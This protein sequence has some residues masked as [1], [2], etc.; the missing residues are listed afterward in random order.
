MQNTRRELGRLWGPPALALIA[1]FNTPLGGPLLSTHSAGFGLSKYAVTSLGLPA[2]AVI[3]G[4]WNAKRWQWLLV[5]G[6]LAKLVAVIESHVYFFSGRPGLTFLISGV[7]DA[8]FVLIVIGVLAAVRDAAMAAAVVGVQLVAA[9][10]LGLDWLSSPYRPMAVDLLLAVIGV[11]GGALAV[12][13]TRTGEIPRAEPIGRRAVIVGT[14]AALVPTVLT[15][16]GYLIKLELPALVAAAGAGVTVLLFVTVL[17]IALGKGALLRTATAG[18]V[19]LAVAAPLTLALYF[20][21]SSPQVYGPA[22][23]IGLAAGMLA[24][25]AGRSMLLAAGACAVLAVVT[26][27]STEL[28][29]SYAD[30]KQGGLASLMIVLGVL[31][32]TSAAA[33]AAP[34]L[35][36]L[37]ALPVAL[38]PLL[39]GFLLGFRELIQPFLSYSRIPSQLPEADYTSLW[40]AILG[41][42]AVAMVAIA[43]LDRAKVTSPAGASVDG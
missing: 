16:T 2:L 33:T 20:S 22:A 13:G 11:V 24:G 4:V 30:L 9:L 31:A 25:H 41:I 17:A 29:G 5:V 43:A 14:L 34:A 7:G 10:F 23:V 28:T 18:L 8:G 40:A 1:L 26:L 36:E 39:I 35:I 12:Y 15:V 21:A 6:T 3:A 38:G 32:A 27:T 42:A 37:R 19:L